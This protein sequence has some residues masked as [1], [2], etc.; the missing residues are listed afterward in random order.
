MSDKNFYWGQNKHFFGGGRGE[1]AVKLTKESLY[2]LGFNC[3]LVINHFKILIQINVRNPN[4]IYKQA[5]LGG[6]SLQ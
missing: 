3:K 5:Q 4:Y 2:R 6:N 1:G